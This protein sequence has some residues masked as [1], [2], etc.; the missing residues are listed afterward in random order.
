M[1]RAARSKVIVDLAEAGSPSMTT[2][3]PAGMRPG[4]THSMDSRGILDARRTAHPPPGSA[5]S[6]TVMSVNLAP[7][8]CQAPR[9][10]PGG[11]V[12]G[13]VTIPA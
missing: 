6:A 1:T 12:R 3:L 5:P 7:P 9:C 13:G 11:F 8:G 4:Q 10:C 2:S